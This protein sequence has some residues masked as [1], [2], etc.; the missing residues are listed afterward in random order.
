M[1]HD[2]HELLGRGIIASRTNRMDEAVNYLMLAGKI[3]PRNIRILLW[4]VASTASAA[5]KRQLLERALQIAPNLAPAQ[6]LLRCLDG[7]AHTAER[8]PDDF[9]AFACPNCGGKQRFDPDLSGLVCAYCKQVEYL[10]S[11]NALQNE[12]PLSA[13]LVGGSGDWALLNS[14]FACSACG[15]KLSV[16]A[17]RSTTTCPFCNSDHIAIQS[18]TPDLIH[19]TAIIPFQL[20]ADDVERIL[21]KSRIP[22]RPEPAPALTP[23][24][25]PFWTFDARIQVRCALGYHVPN[26]VFSEHE[27]V[28]V[29]ENW[30]QKTSWYECKVDDLLLYAGHVSF[31]DLV[32]Q[33]M[34]FDLKSA[35]E[36]RPAMLAGWQAE[37]YQVALSDAS[38]EALQ[39]LRKQAFHSAAKRRLFMREETMLQDDIRVLDRTYKLLLLPVWLIRSTSRDGTSQAMVNGQTGKIFTQTRF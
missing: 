18:A 8:A 21:K 22:R 25:L 1:I 37:L 11:S 3:E 27:R 6:A 16:P 33:I 13:D 26:E 4:L 30:P 31:A 32:A 20:H 23:I 7:V 10:R 36:Y 12:T 5:Q 39:K 9:A 17:G 29:E 28:I 2:F 34:P 35:L 14:E 19:P 24:Y 38:V 15:A